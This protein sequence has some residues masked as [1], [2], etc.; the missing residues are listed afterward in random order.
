MKSTLNARSSDTWWPT[1]IESCRF[2]GASIFFLTRTMF[3]VAVA[4]LTWLRS[5]ETSSVVGFA[6]VYVRHD[7]ASRSWNPMKLA[8]R[9]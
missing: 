5:T 1:P 4:G 3:G 7:A 9:S 8:T 2:S 6:I